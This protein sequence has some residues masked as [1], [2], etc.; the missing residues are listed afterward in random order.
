MILPFLNI[1]FDVSVKLNDMSIDDITE[2]TYVLVPPIDFSRVNYCFQT[3]HNLLNFHPQNVLRTFSSHN[4]TDAGLKI[5]IS[6]AQLGVQPYSFLDHILY[7]SSLYI[8]AL[9]EDDQNQ[10]KFLDNL[11]VKQNA[12]NIISAIFENDRLSISD[13]ILSFV[14]YSCTK[15]LAKQV[16]SEQ[17][18]LELPLA[19]LLM[20]IFDRKRVDINSRLAQDDSVLSKGN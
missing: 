6:K 8:E 20:K 11:T 19:Q 13:S 18:Y 1:L 4:A 9:L 16:I 17:V 15:M 10:N 2:K 5:P 7:I 14:I 12:R 3:I